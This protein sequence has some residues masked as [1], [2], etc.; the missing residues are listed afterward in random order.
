LNQLCDPKNLFPSL[1]RMTKSTDLQ[2]LASL[3]DC[4]FAVAMTLLAFS[5][6]LPEQGLDKAKLPGE[7]AQMF[8]ESSGLVVS[9]VSA[10][11]FWV[12]HFRLLRCLTP[13][14]CRLDLPEPFAAFLDRAAPDLNQ[15]IHPDSNEGNDNDHGSESDADRAL[16]TANVDLFVSDRAL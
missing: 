14:V 16:R 3:S 1:F 7:L 10:A 2:R 9:F 13:Y 11:M 8:W 6:R 5:V 4:V 12:G 15:P